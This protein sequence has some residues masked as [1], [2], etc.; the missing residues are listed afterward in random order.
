MYFLLHNRDM[1]YINI[2]E[3]KSALTLY[4]LL[5]DAM[6]KLIHSVKAIHDEVAVFRPND[7]IIKLAFTGDSRKI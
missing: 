3:N 4:Y 7:V 5:T 2:L 1:L 6:C